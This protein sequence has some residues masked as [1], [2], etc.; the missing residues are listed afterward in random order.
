[1]PRLSGRLVLRG[2]A[3]LTVNALPNQVI[4]ATLKLL[5]RV[6]DIDRKEGLPQ[7]SFDASV[8]TR[9]RS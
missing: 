4:K 3:E 7:V 8:S 5:A 9:S 1:M 2:S 6:P